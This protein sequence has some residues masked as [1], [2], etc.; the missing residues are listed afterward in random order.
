MMV[1]CEQSGE[2]RDAAP[3]V[4]PA[5]WRGLW[6]R[7][8]RQAAGV[9]VTVANAGVVLTA[10]LA[11]RLGLEQLVDATVDLGD[12]TGAARPGRKVMTLVQSMV[13]GGDC[14]DDAEVLRSGDTEAVLPHRAMAPSTLG[15]FLRSFTFGHSRQLDKVVATALR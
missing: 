6:Q 4:I 7:H 1:P 13:L 2:A 10:T 14:I 15:T 3:G 8:K 9:N 11:E 12:R 5:H